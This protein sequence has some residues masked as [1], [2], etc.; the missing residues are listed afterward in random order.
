MNRAEFEERQRAYEAGIANRR[1][2]V[3]RWHE[4]RFGRTA[5]MGSDAARE[6]AKKQAAKAME[7]AIECQMVYEM[8]KAEIA[9]FGAGGREAAVAKMMS[10]ESMKIITC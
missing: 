8:Q 1:I 7:D 3:R 10:E 4:M 6:E 9:A 5:F 2:D